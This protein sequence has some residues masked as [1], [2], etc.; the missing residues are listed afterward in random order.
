[1]KKEKVILLGGIVLTL[2]LGVWAIAWAADL[3]VSNNL[4]LGQEGGPY[5][6]KHLAEPGA[7]DSAAT[8]GYAKD[9]VNGVHSFS[10]V[11]IWRQ[12][13]SDVYLNKDATL[14]LSGNVGIG[15]ND[16]GHPLDIRGSG[17]QTLQVKSTSATGSRGAEIRLGDETGTYGEFWKISSM[18][19][20]VNKPLV[21]GFAD[22]QFQTD[23][24]PKFWID[25]DANDDVS[26][27]IGNAGANESWSLLSQGSQTNT[28]L[29]FK[30]CVA[31]L[32]S[33]VRGTIR[34]SLIDDQARIGIGTTEPGAALH[35]QQGNAWITN[36]LLVG[37][38]IGI[39]E[40]G[41]PGE[42]G[43]RIADD[44]YI[45]DDDC[46]TPSWPPETMPSSSTLN[47][48]SG[49]AIAIKSGGDGK[50]S[51]NYGIY[52]RTD[53]NVGIKGTGGSYAL[54]VASAAGENPVYIGDNLNVGGS[55]YVGGNMNIDGDMN[56]SGLTFAGGIGTESC[57]SGTLGAM[58]YYESSGVAYFQVCMNSTSGAAWYT[59]ESH[60]T[61]GA[62]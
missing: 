35:V 48:T 56:V 20:A 47:I 5:E 3:K 43:I 23:Q 30:Y 7:D 37:G 9:A 49:D 46:T 34:F 17:V 21:F 12:N 62:Y 41:S 10:Y 54:H 2:I 15:T 6:I 45:W 13:A 38:F 11:G 52:V 51:T 42:K 57:T 29:I 31:E 8:W 36:D 28:P 22:S 60:S 25:E 16:P 53:G 18:G 32:C 1:M 50:T 19:D 33:S 40:C 26:I 39:T 4:N 24:D 27:S 61:S 44:S 55:A 58:R 59:I 14:G